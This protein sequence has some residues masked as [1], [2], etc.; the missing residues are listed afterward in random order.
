ML[1]TVPVFPETEPQ[2]CRD[3]S[4]QLEISISDGRK[5]EVFYSVEVV[6]T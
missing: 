5:V 2:S 1:L 4:L 3:P 6:S